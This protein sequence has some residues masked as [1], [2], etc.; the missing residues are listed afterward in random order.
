MAK[1][2]SAKIK[3]QVKV[4]PKPYKKVLVF[5][6]EDLVY[7]M[8]DEEEVR[9]REPYVGKYILKRMSHGGIV[10]AR[11]KLMKVRMKFKGLNKEE[12]ETGVDGEFVPDI[13]EYQDAI[14]MYSLV[15][16]PF[17][18]MPGDGWD[19]QQLKD[20]EKF[21]FKMPENLYDELEEV[22]TDMNN[23]PA[24]ERKN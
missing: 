20:M 6:I 14:L 17:A 5:K 7:N 13:N 19:E 18:K 9:D 16:S 24:K 4:K 15:E 11:S 2:N 23:V 10:A 22:A 21:F 8:D 12:E 1:S 3:K